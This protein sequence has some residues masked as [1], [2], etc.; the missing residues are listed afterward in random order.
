MRLSADSHNRAEMTNSG[1]AYAIGGGVRLLAPRKSL[2]FPYMERFA[3]SWVQCGGELQRNIPVPRRLRSAIG[4]LGVDF[5]MW[6]SSQKL[7][8][9]GS[10][11]IESVAWPWSHFREIVPVMWDVWPSYV[12]HLSRFIRRNKVRLLFCTSQQ[13]TE[14]LQKI[15]PNVIVKWLPEGIDIS[16]YPKGEAIASRPVDI[17]EFGR[18]KP[19]VHDSVAKI[20]AKLGLVHKF[21][22]GKEYL[23][24]DFES[25]T[26]G[27]RN[28]KISLCFPQCDTNPGKAGNV[29]TLTQRY[30]ECMLSGTLIC[31][32]APKELV[33]LCGYDPVIPLEAHSAGRI[34]EL[35][36]GNL[37]RY[38]ELADK[39]RST[40]LN[41]SGWDKRMPI[42]I[43]G[44]RKLVADD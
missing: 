44:L 38:Q 25:L 14:L 3:D 26:R 21:Q 33:D 15:H 2:L 18:R 36:I 40:A 16:L 43:E 30:W 23:F 24:P 37:D 22:K 19:E 42:V 27:I 17:L 28:A 32:R 8:C 7:L 41:I 31:G 12:E 20:A 10:G 29:E 34:L 39:N 4:H 11:R 13:Q 5:R 1:A 35:V 9:L 6:N